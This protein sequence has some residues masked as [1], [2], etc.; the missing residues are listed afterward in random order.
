MLELSHWKAMCALIGL[1]VSDVQGIYTWA[2]TLM[3]N[4]LP[5]RRD[6]WLDNV[7][8]F[9]IPVI[10]HIIRLVRTTTA[11]YAGVNIQAR[12]LIDVMANTGSFLMSEREV[13]TGKWI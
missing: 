7:N 3:I 9:S 2:Q 11:I 1:G 8:L 12:L 4:D 5:P 13:F 10:N 6:E